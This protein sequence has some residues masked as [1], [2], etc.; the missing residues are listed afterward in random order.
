M[1][2]L[3]EYDKKYNQFEYLYNK[4]PQIKKFKISQKVRYLFMKGVE[5][6]KILDKMI[7]LMENDI[8]F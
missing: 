4:L 8:I 6:E 7:E 5:N 1:N 3:S 2:K